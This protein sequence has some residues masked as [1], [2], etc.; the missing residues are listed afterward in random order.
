MKK[1]KY[2]SVYYRMKGMEDRNGM[3]TKRIMPYIYIL[4]AAVILELTVFSFSF[5]K[6]RGN[7]E[8]VTEPEIIFGHVDM[9]EILEVPAGWSEQEVWQ[10]ENGYIH[11]SGGE[12]LLRL[13]D[14]NEKT[15]QI[16]LLLTLPQKAQIRA[17]I[18][19]TDEGNA[20]P[21]KLGEERTIWEWEPKSH[22]FMVY[23]YGEVQDIAI[24]LYTPVL[25]E[26]LMYKLDGVVLN[27][28]AD[29]SFSLLR[30][31]LVFGVLLILYI[32]AGIN[33]SAEFAFWPEQM[34]VRQRQGRNAIVLLCAAV[35]ILLAAAAVLS[36][37]ACRKNLGLHH[38]QY[39]E[40]AAAL[41]KGETWVARA[42]ERL[43]QVEN[44]YDTIYLQANQIPYQADYAYRD[45]KYY[46]YF[47]IVPEL[48]CYLPVYLLTGHALPNYLA[49]LLFVTGFAASCAG[50]AYELMRQYFSKIS[51]VLYPVLVFL[52]AFAYPLFYMQLRP[53]LY[54]V[55]IAASCMFTFLS[56][57][58]ILL[59]KRLE[60][61]KVSLWG[62]GALCMALNAGCR[63]QFLIFSLFLPVLCGKELWGIFEKSRRK[64]SMKVLAAMAVP[65]LAVAAGIMYYNAVRFGSPFD[66]GATY[67]MTSNDMTHR[68]FNLSR[69]VY[70][71]WYYLFAPPQIEGAFPYLQSAVILADYP[72]RL[73]SENCFG[74]IFACSMLYWPVLTF[75]WSRRRLREKRLCGFAAAGIAGALIICAADA[76]GAGVLQRYMA[77]M[78]P[79][80]A[81]AAAVM[82][83]TIA[84]WCE[85]KGI[86]RQFRGWMAAA[87]LLH[88]AFLVLILINADSSVSIRNG[89][90]VLYSKIWSLLQF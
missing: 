24:W 4:L 57:W 62:A 13:R 41:S 19:M 86:S 32:T 60:N 1:L 44:P 36:N 78:M 64:E 46:V 7:A 83:L 88:M 63:P 15:E 33:S 37:P 85:E 9:Q 11:V 27:G 18:Y 47:G 6:T 34:S 8:Q 26:E 38:A 51:F 17:E 48:L 81:L 5:W 58:L 61:W 42:D 39:Q 67:S 72:G 35:F 59:G 50:F 53:D 25:G 69:I 54:H 14:V 43:L 90:A 12:I 89:N 28:R 71:A 22:V 77:D 45:G 56:L 55:P 16:R 68:G 73:V 10:D 30:V 21:Y 79:G 40:L 52:L 3:K 31:L 23:P 2:F 66:F 84:E 82:L 20:Y 74:G 70:S 76:S 49:M 65:Y 80:I 75:G 29:F 87:L